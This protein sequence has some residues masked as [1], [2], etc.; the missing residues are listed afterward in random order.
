MPAGGTNSFTVNGDVM[1]IIVGVGGNGEFQIDPEGGMAGLGNRS[2][3]GNRGNGNNPLES[4][5][6]NGL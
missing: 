5:Q 6:I 4:S 1:S 3:N 2:P